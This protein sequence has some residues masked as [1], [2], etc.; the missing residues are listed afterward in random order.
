ML[1]KRVCCKILAG[2]GR[3]Q[4]KNCGIV[5]VDL[6]ICRCQYTTSKAGGGVADDALV[7]DKADDI[8][9]IGGAG[10][11]REVNVG[12]GAVSDSIDE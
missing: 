11:K 8:L 7:V 9:N 2:S 3:E 6:C 5:Q 1:F 12:S 4:I 10:E